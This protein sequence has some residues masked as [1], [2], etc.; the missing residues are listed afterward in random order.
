M[1]SNFISTYNLLNGPRLQSRTAQAEIARLGKEIVDARHADV[2]LVLGAKTGHAT[3]LYQELG[4]VQAFTTSNGLVAGRL[5]VTQAALSEIRD[6][7]DKTLATLVGL[8][9]N[10]LGADTIRG[11]AERTLKALTDKLNSAYAGQQLF[12]G[13]KTDTVPVDVDAGKDKVQDAFATF[14]DLYRTIYWDALSKPGVP[15]IEEIVPDAFGIFLDRPDPNALEQELRDAAGLRGAP[16]ND[17]N[18]PE[19]D[20]LRNLAIAVRNGVTTAVAPAGSASGQDAPPAPP[21]L[22]QS[23]QKTDLALGGSITLVVDGVA[24]PPISFANAAELKAE[25]EALPSIAS[26]TF[27]TGDK[28]NEL[29]ITGAATGSARSLEVSAVTVRSAAHFDAAFDDYHWNAWSSASDTNLTSNISNAES[30]DSSVNANHAA[31]Q[32]LARAYAVLGALPAN[33]L[34]ESAFK[35]AVDYA[36]KQLGEAVNGVTLLQADVGAAQARVK[37]VN[38][39]LA[40]QKTLLQRNLTDLEGVDPAAA[41]VSLDTVELQ[42]SLSYSL[43]ARLQKLNLLNYL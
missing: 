39:S 36:I 19:I 30:I 27:G 42:L 23:F 2:G 6:A 12:A 7:A 22:T 24:L 16:F 9:T 37:V 4:R 20:A 1:A 3:V 8:P 26:A 43:T 31:F 13:V 14:R 28:Y 11:E 34:N 25:L 41:K 21:V 32:Q 38:E 33:Q 15:T 5:D 10:Q 17:P 29:T 40:T 35:S 18:T